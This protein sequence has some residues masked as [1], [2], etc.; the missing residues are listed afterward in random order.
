MVGYLVY[1]YRDT[2]KIKFGRS[3][4]TVFVPFNKGSGTPWHTGCPTRYMKVNSKGK[5]IAPTGD[6]IPLAIALLKQHTSGGKGMTDE[7]L[8]GWF[9]EFVYTQKKYI[10]LAGRMVGVANADKY[11][12]FSQFYLTEYRQLAKILD[13]EIYLNPDRAPDDRFIEYMFKYGDFWVI[14]LIDNPNY[15]KEEENND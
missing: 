13:K 11:V 5:I 1:Q 15:N 9:K 10:R 2:I 14:C 12:Q 4:G 7:Q 6:D 3:E 8:L